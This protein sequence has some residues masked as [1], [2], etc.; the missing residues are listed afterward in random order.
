[1]NDLN[2]LANK[3]IELQRKVDSLQNAVIQLQ[4]KAVKE[5]E[6]NEK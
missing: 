4:K 5:S 6:G 2:F 3:I 1:M